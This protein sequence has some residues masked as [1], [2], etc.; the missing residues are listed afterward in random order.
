MA[1][2]LT[3]YEQRHHSIGRATLVPVAAILCLILLV[4]LGCFYWLQQNQIKNRVV[5]KLDSIPYLLTL[6]EEQETELITHFFSHYDGDPLLI[7]AFRNADRQG[8]LEAV[9]PLY[10]RLNQH[11]NITHF[12]FHSTDKHCF[13]RVHKPE[14]YGDRI[15]RWTLEEAVRTG[16]T[17]SGV[18]LGPLGMLTLRV[19]KPWRVGNE[20][21][22]YLELGKEIGFL[23]PR[24]K[25]ALGVE[26]V[27]LAWKKHLDQ[28]LWEQSM[29][30]LNRQEQWSRFPD[31]VVIDATLPRLPIEVSQAIG[32]SHQEHSGAPIHAH[33]DSIFEGGFVPLLDASGQEIGDI[34]VLIDFSGLR[35]QMWQSF[36]VLGLVVVVA[37][38][39]LFLIFFFRISR[40][41]RELSLAMHC[42]NGKARHFHALFEES[43]FPQ[44]EEDFTEVKRYLDG[45]PC[46]GL[47]EVMNY[48]ADHPEARMECASRAVMKNCNSAMVRMLRATNK[49]GVMRDHR[50]K[51]FLPRS[52]DDFAN[53]VSALAF[54][55]RSGMCESCLRTDDGEELALLVHLQVIAGFEE[56]LGKVV[57][58]FYD[59]TQRKR[60]EE[61]IRASE[62]KYRTLLANIPAKVFYK[63]TA[64]VYLAV[65]AE[66]ASDLG[67]SAEEVVGC[68]DYDFFPP[69]LAAKYQS[70]DRRIMAMDIHE[71]MDESY[72]LHGQQRVVHTIKNTVKDVSGKIIGL[73]GMFWD[74]TEQ[75]AAQ[76]RLRLFRRLIDQANDFI[77]VV[78][79]ESSS[80][81]D[82]NQSFC[83]S[84]GYSREELLGMRVSDVDVNL[85]D[86]TAWRTYLESLW[87]GESRTNESQC[88]RKDG[89][90]LPVEVSGTL[91]RLD[92]RQF[93]LGVVRDISERLLRRAELE[94]ALFKAE[95]ANRA[96]GQFLAN[97]SHEIRTPMNGIM[98]MTSLAL[99][100]ELTSEQR[101]YLSV[102]ND[103]ARSLLTIINDILD[104]SKIEAG[105]LTLDEHPFDLEEL[106]ENTLAPFEMKAHEKGVALLHRLPGS[107][108]VALIGDAMRLRQIL[109]NLVGN[110]VKFT[111]LGHI[112]VDV[113]LHRQEGHAVFL[114]FSVKDTGIGV[115]QDKLESIFYTF[116]Q[117]DNSISRRY[118][119]SGL[120]LTICC[121]LATMMGGDV[122][123]ESEEGRGS[124]FFVS[125]RFKMA[126]LQPF[127][128]AAPRPAGKQGR[129]L[130]LDPLA[131]S[132]EIL[133][134]QFGEWGLSVTT[135]AGLDDEVGR[136]SSGVGDEACYDCIVVSARGGA[137]ANR[138]LVA[139]LAKDPR[140]AATPLAL[141]GA[142]ESVDGM[143][144]GNEEFCC[145]IRRPFRV[146][147][148]QHCLDAV[149]GE[150]KSCPLLAEEEGGAPRGAD[151]RHVRS[152]YV[153]LVED[154]MV[155]LELAQV[156]IEQAGHR[157]AKAASGREALLLLTQTSFDAIF[158]DIQMP[159][160][161]GITTTRIIRQCE[162]GILPEQSEYLQ[163]AEGVRAKIK[164]SRTPII[165]MTAHAMAG[166]R[167][168]CLSAGMDLYVTKP[169]QPE[170]LVGIIAGLSR[171]NG[172]GESGNGDGG[173]RHGETPLKASHAVQGGDSVEAVKGYLREKYRLPEANVD[174][175]F[176]IAQM[177]LSEYVGLLEQ[178]AGQGDF[179][180][181]AKIS[182]TIKGELLQL[183]MRDW[184]ELALTME[185]GAKGNDP[186]VDY[187]GI[188]AQLRV[189][190]GGLLVHAA[191]G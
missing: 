82:V 189:G 131:E 157:V 105:Q 29:E 134:E 142:A 39:T 52:A 73:I 174:H 121:R 59:I 4:S 191:G 54:G 62:L 55:A 26:L 114:L 120:G 2:Q 153:L 163:I 115:A 5:S 128:Y 161:D 138:D 100:T 50:Q 23:L 46:L 70:D 146:S 150:L 66:M 181:L 16:R 65:N 175:L 38:I 126:E 108:P 53:V 190:L 7:Q 18:E 69:E 31:S 141:L 85:P 92:E 158:M 10:Q 147:A 84:L 72:L 6:F 111:E 103:S 136:V 32:R 89:T 88:R 116:T 86:G 48:F 172:N 35:F 164:G 137:A 74:V 9:L 133:A 140:H 42:L 171:D 95:T 45:L 63:D 60:L 87:Q 1:E 122:W 151:G 162:A 24:L 37:G 51:N 101:H 176:Q 14:R 168:E 91:L 99:A 30:F 44:I 81:L 36:F 155:N 79:P 112:V 167:E 165:A 166:D 119:G 11:H 186:D 97:M 67:R 56:T 75:Y 71:A 156:I 187:A 143:A 34:V 78:E 43:P 41:D 117:A 182:H 40:L 90:L 107:V 125:A 154:N 177:T 102:V 28:S 145:V 47:S 118:G 68:T 139:R 106:I 13:L 77:V 183:G 160:M 129:V 123:V 184:A 96:K 21:I 152:L 93:V 3:Q 76:E 110:A 170:Q 104:F 135:R 109:V 64:S 20:I 144:S 113:K 80:F 49:A 188:T 17:V 58:S 83:D 22:G 57:V 178:A 61:E 98:G 185:R 12:Y 33:G 148:L 124:T 173:E 19:V 132:R 149:L 27:V 169:F 179:P 25:Q 94:D 15:Q 8:T 159:E 127:P 180:E 130:L